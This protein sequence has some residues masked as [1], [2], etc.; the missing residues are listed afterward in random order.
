MDVK[1]CLPQIDEI[2]WRSR[3]WCDTLEKMDFSNVE[4]YQKK[5]RTSSL[6]DDFLKFLK[7]QFHCISVFKGE[8]ELIRKWI[9]IHVFK[10]NKDTTCFDRKFFGYLSDTEIVLFELFDESSHTIFEI[11][12]VMDSLPI[13]ECDIPD[14]SMVLLPRWFSSLNNLDDT[15]SPTKPSEWNAHILVSILGRRKK[16][17]EIVTRLESI[18]ASFAEEIEKHDKSPATL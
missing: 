16:I 13:G 11:T 1:K 5:F 15:V 2:I 7:E 4:N 9:H 8:A 14:M 3:G 6:Q 18:L 17:R 10:Q 12:K